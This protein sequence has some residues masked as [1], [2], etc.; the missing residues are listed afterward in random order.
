MSRFGDLGSHLGDLRVALAALED[1]TGTVERWGR[2][3]AAVLDGGGRLLAAGNGGSAAQA[4]HLT[5]ELVGRFESDR[6]PLSAIALHT[7]TSSVTA[8]GND[9]GFDTVFGRQVLAHGR[10]GDVL[11]LLSTSGN[12]ANLLDAARQGRTAGLRVWAM[13]G[14][15]PNP[16]AGIVEATLAV[17]SASAAVV[18]EAHLVAVHA[19][20][21]MVERHLPEPAVAADRLADLT[22]LDLV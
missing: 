3:L 11:L 22:G 14:R 16:L 7:E 13:T 21:A 20:C 17:P 1:Q 4:Q 2:R 8:I 5:A 18:Q 15:S 12:S 9:F 10:A 19:L 6:R